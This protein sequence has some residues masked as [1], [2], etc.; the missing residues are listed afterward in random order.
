MSGSAAPQ[1]ALLDGP[2]LETSRAA[3][4]RSAAGHVHATGLPPGIV[5]RL[6]APLAALQANRTGRSQRDR[7]AAFR[8]LK[9]LERWHDPRSG[10][11]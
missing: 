9:R 6:S 11:R 3:F 10:A 5:E 4:E 2:L 1:R 8:L 7:H